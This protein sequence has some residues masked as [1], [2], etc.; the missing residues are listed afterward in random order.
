LNTEILFD[1]Y[2]ILTQEL[3]IGKSNLSARFRE[4][5]S[6]EDDVGNDF[7]K[8]LNINGTTDPDPQISDTES[9][10]QD[11]Q[12]RKNPKN[13]SEIFTLPTSEKHIL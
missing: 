8:N 4:S 9:K 13:N 1:L 10:R 7:S 3:L 2:F 6:Q 12:Q 5:V 11:N